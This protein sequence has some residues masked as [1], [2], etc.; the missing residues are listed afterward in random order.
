[1][2]GWYG[3]YY[4]G[5]DNNGELVTSRRPPSVEYISSRSLKSIMIADEILTFNATQ[6]VPDTPPF[7]VVENKNNIVIILEIALGCLSSI[8]VALFIIFICFYRGMKKKRR[9]VKKY[10]SL[11]TYT[12]QY[13]TLLQCIL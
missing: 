2:Y 5:R 4:L 13:F 9:N 3:N 1:M 11:N 6:V 12:M 10:V 7:I 8:I